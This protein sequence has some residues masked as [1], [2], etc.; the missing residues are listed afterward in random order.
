MDMQA[1][2]NQM[3]I[4]F[5][6][7]AI[8]YVAGKTKLLTADTGKSVTKI[9]LHILIPST[10]LNSA[11]N[12]NIDITSKDAMFF[13]LLSLLS[14]LVAHIIAIP[15]TRALASHSAG[16]KANRGLYG[17]MAAYGNVA[18]IGFPVANAIF[19]ASS[20]FFVTLYNVPFAVFA[21]SV[22]IIMISNN[23]K[24]VKI[25]AVVNPAFICGLISIA[26]YFTG[27]TM[28][29]FIAEPIRMISSATTPCSMLVIGASLAQIPMM[30]VISKWK[31][32]IVALLKLIIIPTIV[33]LIF[34]QFISSGIMLG[35]LVA[36]SGMPTAST[37][38]MVALEYGGDGEIA[39]SGVFLSTLL[40][41]ASIPLLVYL[42]LR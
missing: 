18:F 17:Y 21:L 13:L 28:P 35:V 7:L 10:I 3:I 25:K 4:L 5:V 38:A 33:W 29:F 24:N 27:F 32:Y 30:K 36:L 19:G 12:G 23:V 6:L 2:I 11:V 20:A 9:V 22:G 26:I 41:C 31:L 1:I 8:G 37:S 34:K 16:D 40:S 39:S 42:L 14:F 15:A